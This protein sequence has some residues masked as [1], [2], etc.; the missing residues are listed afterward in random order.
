MK[1]FEQ[2]TCAWSLSDWQ[3]FVQNNVEEVEEMRLIS[4][5]SGAGVVTRAL[6]VPD[7]HKSW[8]GKSTQPDSIQMAQ[9]LPSVNVSPY[10]PIVTLKL[11]EESIDGQPS[12]LVDIQWAPHPDA[13]MLAVAEW[14]GA[15]LCVISGVVGMQQNPLAGFAIAFGVLLL[16]LPRYR[17]RW[18]FEREM[19]R[20]KDAF[21]TLEIPWNQST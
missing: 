2:R 7:T 21:S 12:T 5:L 9:C 6:E 16:I 18:S 20:A 15:S 17:A 14:I 4:K 11:V 19:Q 10:Q 13:N 3:N 1:V 8:F